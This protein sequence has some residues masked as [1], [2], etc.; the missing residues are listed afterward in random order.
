MSGFDQSRIL[1]LAALT[2]VLSI[3]TAAEASAFSR[4][5]SATGPNGGTYTHQGSGG[6]SGG[7]CSLNSSTTGPNGLTSSHSAT[8]TR[9]GNGTVSVNGTGTGPYGGSYDRS[10]TY[11]R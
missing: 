3:A 7:S 2:A 4:S 1:Q 8:A 6:C 10:V 11:G 5:V 9:N